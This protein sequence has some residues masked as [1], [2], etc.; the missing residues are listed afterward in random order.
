M[1]NTMNTK[2]ESLRK[3][4]SFDPKKYN[5][6]MFFSDLKLFKEDYEVSMRENCSLEYCSVN[7]CNFKITK[8]QTAKLVHV[9]KF[10]NLSIKNGL[11]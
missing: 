9:Q 6:E 1:Y 5:M 10:R 7:S 3:Y 4:Y 11:S 8:T 2:W